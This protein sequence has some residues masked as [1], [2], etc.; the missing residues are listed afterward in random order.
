MG[1]KGSPGR[2]ANLFG[3]TP[4]APLAALAGALALAAGCSGDDGSASGSPTAASGAGAG[5]QAAASSKVRLKRIGTF[6]Q[7]VYLTAPPGDRSRVFVVEQAGRIRVVRSGRK[8]A[9]PFLDIRGSVRA[10]G[11]RGLLGLAF[12]PNYASSRR[13]YVYFTDN[14]GDI[15]V[16]EFRRRAGNA[17]LASRGSRRNVLTIGHHEFPNHNGGSLLFGPD[18]YLWMGVGDGGGAG[19]QHG[20]GQRL[21]TRLGKLLR[22]DPRA[23][24]GR[25]HR[26]PKGNPFRGRRGA[27]PEIWAYGLRNPW[28]FSFDRLTDD[29]SIGDVGQNAWEEIDYRPAGLSAGRGTNFGWSCYEGRHTY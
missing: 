15:H 24:G 4:R 11:E 28:R 5:A 29:L 9:R 13:F 7:P 12:A 23:A 27:K 1:L 18:G 16:Q 20:H 21:S 2:P 6:R 3:V 17:N 26:I 25:G 19:D 8:L 10:G 14:R 22:I